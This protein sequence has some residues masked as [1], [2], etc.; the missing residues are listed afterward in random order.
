M[1]RYL[2]ALTRPRDSLEKKNADHPAKTNNRHLASQCHN[3]HL[4]PTSRSF[5]ADKCDLEICEVSDLPNF[6]GVYEKF[7]INFL[8][9]TLRTFLSLSVHADH[10]L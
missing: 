3:K 8:C 6:P 5:G 9:H 7:T 1:T 4:Y 10:L 2:S